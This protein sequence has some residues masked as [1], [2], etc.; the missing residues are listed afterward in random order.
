MFS[1]LCVDVAEDRLKTTSWP[2]SYTVQPEMGKSRVDLHRLLDVGVGA[3]AGA[4]ITVLVRAQAMTHCLILFGVRS[5]ALA[6]PVAVM[7]S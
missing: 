6:K 1:I 3:V 5:L 4:A 7:W 2:T